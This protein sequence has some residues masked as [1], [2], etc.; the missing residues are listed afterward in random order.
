MSAVASTSAY[1]YTGKDAAAKEREDR[2]LAAKKKLKLYRQRTNQRSSA[3]SILSGSSTTPS[4]SPVKA[5]RRQSGLTSSISSAADF[6]AK[7]AHRRSQS[8]SGLLAA[9]GGDALIGGV[10]AVGH[11][12]RASKSRM[13]RSSISLKKAGHGHTRSRASISMSFSGPA[14]TLA[15][16]ASGSTDR[17]ISPTP[18]TSAGDRPAA[19][20][21]PSS[22][23]QGGSGSFPTSPELARPPS[24]STNAY[25]SS[26]TLARPT[27]PLPPAPAPG[28]P[29][30]HARRGSRHARHSSVSNFRESL[31]IVS[32][33]TVNDASLLRPAISSFAEA[34]N[35]SPSSSPF[36]SASVSASSSWSNDPHQVLAALKERGRRETEDGSRS[37][38]ETRQSALEALEGRLAAPSEMI[39]LGDEAPGE[40]LAA[41]RS[42][43]YLSTAPAGSSAPSS[44]GLS[45]PMIGLGFAGT[46]ASGNVIPPS[47]RNSWGN[48]MG[49]VA[50]VGAQGVLEL[51]EIAEEDEEEDGMS[52]AGSLGS[53]RRRRTSS[54]GS[55]RSSPSVTSP[56]GS[57]TGKS[58]AG[59]PSPRKSRPGSLYIDSRHAVNLESVIEAASEEAAQQSSPS[60]SPTK[61]SSKIRPLSLSASSTSS[62]AATP[63]TAT[64]PTQLHAPS[65]PPDARAPS[66][67][68]EKRHISMFHTAAAL[69]LAP[70]PP[71]SGIATQSA[72][73][74]STPP[75]AA[76]SRGGL[77]SL[78]I[79][80]GVSTSP[81]IGLNERRFSGRPASLQ[82]SPASTIGTP[83]R[84]V[85]P[86]PTNKRSS[87]SYR[88]STDSP[89]SIA[90]STPEGQK[91]A[92]RSS[93]AQQQ[94]PSPSVIS[95]AVSTRHYSSFP[96]GVTG[97]FGDLEVE[98]DGDRTGAPSS[99]SAIS[100][101]AHS[102]LSSLADAPA[103]LA[104][105]EDELASLRAK[106]EELELR[107]SQLSSTHALEIAEFEKKASDE[108]R[109]MRSRIAELESQVEEERVA[110]RFET[111]GLQ[112]ETDM[113]KE[114]IQDLTDE[115]DSL[116]EDVDGW[117]TRCSGLEAQLK[118]E[119][120]EDA[121]AQA[122]AKLI[123]EMRDQIY[124]LV[125]ALERERNEHA[126]TRKEVERIL[127]DRVRE[128]AAD[129][130]HHKQASS[131]AS[132]A[133]SASRVTPPPP[134]AAS[135]ERQHISSLS[136]TPAT[137]KQPRPDDLAL[138]M[139]E[140]EDDAN[141]DEEE[142]DGNDEREPSRLGGTRHYSKSTSEGSMLSSLSSFGRSYTGNLTEDTSVLTDMDDSYS[143]KV[144]SPTSV[145]SSFGSGPFPPPASRT[146]DS[147]VFAVALGQLD[148][149]AEE[150]EED[151]E[152]AHG[153]L[154]QATPLVDDSR[155]RT[156]SD[157]TST[158]S[159]V[160][161]RTPDKS[162][163]EHHHR[164]Y[165]F[166]RNWSF[167]KGS[168]SSTRN[169]FE[170][171][172]QTFFG[173]N[174]HDSLPPLPIGDHILPPFLSST[175][176]IDENHVALVMPPPVEG[177]IETAHIRR[178]SS[179][180]PL[181]RVNPHTRR[182]SGQH[183]PPPPSPSAMVSVALQ[184][185][186]QG[187]RL[188]QSSS[189][190]SDLSP[191]KSRYSF[192]ALVGSVTGWS[193]ASSTSSNAPVHA[194]LPAPASSK[195]NRPPPPPMSA[196][197][198]IVEED[199]PEGREEDVYMTSTGPVHGTPAQLQHQN[200]RRLRSIRPEE[201]PTPK[202]GKLSKLD[203]TRS[204]CCI[205]EPVFVV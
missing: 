188:S 146:R 29:P 90:A 30:Q 135:R 182:L 26:S 177:T 3:S 172:D 103:S 126:E 32:N 180:R 2:L 128:A 50:H 4:S 108:A 86:A 110:R 136:G 150:E 117:R 87:I 8:K 203:F 184:H 22:W 124:T 107:N 28:P 12:R 52:E 74:M 13:S 65:S 179:P 161:P 72:L 134:S 143:S 100:S 61:R 140:V 23:L 73:A 75:P 35:V 149:L 34:S 69:G 27:S 178:P 11:A 44:V 96:F 39:S 64:S 113:A 155:P 40:L 198:L 54:R 200:Q 43:G 9:M 152:A 159:D 63:S 191:T 42:P 111:E 165:S 138:I 93:L 60:P 77:R 78:S 53:P 153:D 168:I 204:V 145:H 16:Q 38:E 133:S 205:D 36:P 147:D 95:P 25:A 192:G 169:S 46:T 15:P 158:S 71:A 116:R 51:G 81:T 55:V 137:L 70:D 82:V 127:E 58:V 173:Y 163:S 193:P 121:L 185:Q 10:G 123:G 144:H 132:N 1:S 156:S 201:Q 94:T 109:E 131:L 56:R 48:A 202:A 187:S 83:T 67:I 7:H 24:F 195:V 199:E 99:V 154:S 114:A 194:G 196:G 125:A 181:D 162:S 84:K 66:P 170:D 106:V 112:R 122:Q 129:V 189:T 139:E 91:R 186:Q 164:S 85:S 92:W 14:P 167:P 59:S 18:R 175:L 142:E 101:P 45:S 57:V 115:R 151:E 160:M 104:A 49:H 171:D 6:S 20:T 62:P 21:T 31:D 88:T 79:G 148:T 47:K 97:G 76:Q 89:A 197:P 174:K 41:P 33:G 19:L 80:S 157:S 176:D 120:E 102:R 105:A 98:D 166:V 183:R 118:K 37:P 119:K 68:G 5:T 130:Q 17:P 190:P 141:A